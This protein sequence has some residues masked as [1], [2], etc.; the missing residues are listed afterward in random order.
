MYRYI[1]SSNDKPIKNSTYVAQ[2][3]RDKFGIEPY[4]INDEFIDY[5]ANE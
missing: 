2:Q 3:L 1:R 4:K 5:K